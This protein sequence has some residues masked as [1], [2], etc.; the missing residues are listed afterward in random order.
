MRSLVTVG[1]FDG[2]HRGHQRL[3]R[4]LLAEAE[5]SRL[6]PAVVLFDRPPRFFFHPEQAGPLITTVEERRTLLAGLGVR[7]VHVLPFNRHMAHVSH[8][9][10]FEEYLLRRCLAGGLL[11]GPDFAFGRDR[12][13]DIGWLTHACDVLGLRFSILPLIQAGGHKIGSSRIRRLLAEGTVG[14]AARLLGRRYALTGEVH[15]GDGLGRRLGVPT[16]NLAVCEEKIAPPGVFKVRVRSADGKGRLD[17]PG[18]CNVGTRPSVCDAGERRI[19]VHV[20]GF[21]GS[22][23]GRR[24]T[25][26]FLRRLRPERRFDSV[27]ALRE[28]IRRDIRA[29]AR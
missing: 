24:L 4:R 12:K 21:S 17:R 20:L 13:G 3:V 27:D 11:V 25:V 6:R 23:Y 26:E 8:E 7:S 9:R 19:E 2:V 22:L 5:R 10:F 15:K 16:A 14:E 18:V 28:Q 1:T 29:A